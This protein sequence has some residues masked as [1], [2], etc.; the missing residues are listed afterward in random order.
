MNI[1]ILRG[2]ALS[3]CAA[4]VAGLLSFLGL[5]RLGGI[6]SGP[7]NPARPPRRRPGAR[8]GVV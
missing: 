3:L 2:V 8:R 4:T 5:R 1:E 6:E 7:G